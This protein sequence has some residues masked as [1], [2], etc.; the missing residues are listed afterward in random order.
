[1]IGLIQKTLLDFVEHHK[2]PEGVVIVKR[3]A[4]VDPLCEFRIGDVY[5]D[6]EWRRLAEAAFEFVN[7]P[8]QLFWEGLVE[9]FAEITLRLFPAWFKMAKSAREF[10]ELQPTIQ[11]VFARGLHNPGAQKAVREKFSIQVSPLSIIKT[12]CSPNKLCK[13]YVGMTYWLMRY[14]G[15]QAEITEPKCLHRGDEECEIHMTWTEQTQ[16]KQAQAREV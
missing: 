13:L 16:G 4:Q 2:G 11:N 7:M 14:Y 12:Y 1:M 5:S 3:M 10:I 15:D 6:K 8:E 9:E